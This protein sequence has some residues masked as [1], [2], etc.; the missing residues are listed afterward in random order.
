LR[1]D[2]VH[3]IEDNSAVHFVHELKQAVNDL[4]V[5]TGKKKLL[6]A[7]LDLNDKRF[8]DAPEYGGYG[9]D[10]QWV[11]EFHHAL[12][13]V[14]TGEQD[15]YYEDFGTL[16][17]LEH[18]YRN[19]YVYNGIYSKH[20]KR[21]F[22][23]QPDHPY[24]KYVIFAQNHDQVGNRPTGNRLASSISFEGLKLAA[25][26]ILLSPYT[27]LLFMGEEYAEKNPFLY[28][29]DHED[30]T[31][32]NNI[33]KG[34]QKEFCYFNFEE[35]F[36]EP[37]MPDTFE[38]SKLSWNIDSVERATMLDFYKHLIRFRKFHPVMQA[39]ERSS[40]LVHPAEGSIL[41]I[42]RFDSIGRLLIV[43][44]TGKQKSTYTNHSTCSY[45]KLMDSSDLIWN[46]PAHP[47][48]NELKAGKSAVINP[49]S[50]SVYQSIS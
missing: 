33:S 19:T 32:K 17:H 16:Q 28:F 1:M 26:A 41:S 13:S 46:G 44:N 40:M 2:A 37:H 11:D 7:E 12:R 29:V 34:R 27:P 35:G 23:T 20:R 8:L 15:G 9:L 3:S 50:V 42:E 45:K 22:G 30:E 14:L 18:A 6:I 5:R 49:L 21:I 4:E 10:G 47:G 36:P 39:R 48:F 25:A 31:L 24:F 38:Q 43:M